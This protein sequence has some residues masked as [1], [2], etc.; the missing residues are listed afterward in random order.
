MF[1]FFFIYYLFI[2]FIY[3][4]QHGT[5]P[6]PPWPWLA[7]NPRQ[8]GK[9]GNLN[10]HALARLAQGIYRAMHQGFG[11]T[12]A[13]GRGDQKQEAESSIMSPTETQNPRNPRGWWG[14]SGPFPGQGGKICLENHTLGLSLTRS[15]SFFNVVS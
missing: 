11:Q 1:F 10:L 14:F 12:G 7:E 5:G 13:A 4:G 8:K 3:S 2:F 9:R 15:S 6:P